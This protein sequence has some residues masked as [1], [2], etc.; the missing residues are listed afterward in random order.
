M[1]CILFPSWIAS[2]PIEGI[3]EELSR[4]MRIGRR[5]PDFTFSIF[6]VDPAL[7]QG[8]IFEFYDVFKECAQR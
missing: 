7:A 1:N 4:L 2:T 3:R 8:R 6:E 5:F